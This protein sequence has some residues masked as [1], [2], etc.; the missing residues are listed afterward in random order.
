M[1]IGTT[2][3]IFEHPLHPYT[4]GLLNSIPRL[5]QETRFLTPIVGSVCNMMEAPPG[6]KFHPRC[7]QAM[8]ICRHEVP[9][10]RELAPGHYTACHLHSA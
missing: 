1:E 6:C 4:V 10:M 9:P 7:S 3:E 5:D 2:Q 8:D